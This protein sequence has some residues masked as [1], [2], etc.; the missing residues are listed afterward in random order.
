MSD[1]KLAFRQ[2]R[3]WAAH[4]QQEAGF[5]DEPVLGSRRST[6]KIE[7]PAT[8]P[9]PEEGVPRPKSAALQNRDPVRRSAPQPQ[10]SPVVSPFLTATEAAQYCRLSVK[11][12]E[13]YRKTGGG[14]L[15]RKGG[16]S[17]RSKSRVVYHIDD[18]DTWLRPMT[19]TSDTRDRR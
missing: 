11:T 10:A 17:S 3:L 19:S 14:P 8:D 5:Y 6:K 9:T 4:P 15:F 13:R 1:R 2:R 12:L 7:A 18:L 16:G